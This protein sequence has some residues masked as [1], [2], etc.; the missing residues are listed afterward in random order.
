VTRLFFVE[1]SDVMD[2]LATFVEP[3]LIVGDI[4]IRMDTHAI[5]LTDALTAHDLSNCVSSAT[6]DLGG[7][8]DVVAT[9]AD[10][11]LPSVDVL[12]IGLSN[13]RLL[14]WKA[15]LVRPC[16][17]YTTSTGRSWSRLDPEVLRRELRSSLLCRP[18]AWSVL[19]VD[20]MAQFYDSEQ[21][22]VLDRLIPMRTTTCRKRTSD[23]WFDD[24]CRVAK[25][26][27]RL[28]ERD[29]RRTSR[30]NPN[31]VAA[32]AATAAWF[33]RRHD[34]RIMLQE[35]RESKG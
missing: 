29:A 8:L 25:R 5:Q 27:V 28:F 14:S 20:G 7:S 21:T 10:L 12:G 26:S 31:S 19:D 33:A 3:V 30:T 35:K 23:P 9:R 2:R 11:P 17:V 4:N 32:A 15:P 6:H 1:L 24:D 34:Y 13:H 22:A 16:P 18:Q